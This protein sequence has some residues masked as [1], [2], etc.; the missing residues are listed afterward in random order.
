MAPA[1]FCVR[2]TGVL[3]S[4]VREGENGLLRG[5]LGRH[6]SLYGSAVRAALRRIT[7]RA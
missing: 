3:F 6:P 1:P 7:A 2:T 4:E 5:V